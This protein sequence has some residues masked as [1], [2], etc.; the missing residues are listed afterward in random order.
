MASVNSK[1]DPATSWFKCNCMCKNVSKE[2]ITSQAS[3]LQLTTVRVIKLLSITEEKPRYSSEICISKINLA[4]TWSL[5]MLKK[6]VG[7]SKSSTTPEV[8]FFKANT[9]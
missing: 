7:A 6:L 5:A 3:F 9:I 1:A 4:E 2:L 8:K